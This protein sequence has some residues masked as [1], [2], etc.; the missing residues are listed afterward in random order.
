MTID[1]VPKGRDGIAG[2]VGQRQVR[3]DGAH[4]PERNSRAGCG[5]V[6]QLD[7]GCKRTP[8]ITTQ[9]SNIRWLSELFDASEVLVRQSI[10]V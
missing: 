5:A 1:F 8:Q 2:Y 10:S 9:I 3:A 4:L 6:S 7:T